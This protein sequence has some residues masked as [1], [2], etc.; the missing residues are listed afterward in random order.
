MFL[1]IDSINFGYPLAQALINWA[2]RLWL[3]LQLSKRDM[4]IVEYAVDILCSN[5]WV[6]FLLP[7]KLL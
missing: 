3:V 4:S 6:V 2:C 7:D 5:K 1:L